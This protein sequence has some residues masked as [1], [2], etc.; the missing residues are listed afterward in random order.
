[1]RILGNRQIDDRKKNG[2]RFPHEKSSRVRNDH[3]KKEN[4]KTSLDL[5][6]STPCQ[7]RSITTDGV[8]ACVRI[9]AAW[10]HAAGQY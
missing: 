4:H 6:E 2:S 3:R 5:Q 9:P 10:Q 8:H 7:A 1:M